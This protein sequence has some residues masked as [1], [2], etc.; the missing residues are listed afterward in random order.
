MFVALEANTIL[1]VWLLYS[2]LEAMFIQI[3]IYCIFSEVIIKYYSLR[4][5]ISVGDFVLSTK[6]ILSH[7]HL[8]P[9]GGTRR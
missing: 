9:I 2:L 1:F 6:F 7:R 5:E 3:N 8:F 4:S